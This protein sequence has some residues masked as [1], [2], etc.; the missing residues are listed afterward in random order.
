MSVL[1][2]LAM[3]VAAQPAPSRR[4]VTQADL[5]SMADA[6]HAPRAWLMLRGREV[7]F[8]GSP[9]AD[10]GKVECVLKK[11]SAVVPMTDIGFIGNAQVLKEK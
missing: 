3:Q 7:V 10:Y 1:F 2:A 6:C 9:N 5:N 8:R 4:R 11:I